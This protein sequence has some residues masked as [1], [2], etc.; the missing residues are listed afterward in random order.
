M[1]AFFSILTVLLVM[2][3]NAQKYDCTVKTKE[4]QD[5]IKS[6]KIAESYNDWNEVRKNCPKENEAI[7]TDGITI[8]EY[9]I[10]NVTAVEE[11]E[12]LVREEMS[13][14]DQYYRNFP[15]S[16][17]N[18]EAQKAMALY[19]HKIEANNEIVELLNS[20]FTKT[21]KSITEAN[22]FYTY[23]SL[24][25]AKY[26]EDS[27]NYTSDM[28]LDKYMQINTLIDALISTN[29]TKSSD[30]KSAQR[31]IHALAKDITNCDVLS[32]Y[33]EK[34][35]ENNK[36]NA[37]WL[38]TAL[39]NFTV[40]CSGQPIYNAMAEANYKIKATTKSAYYLAN[41]SMKQRKF[42]E[43]I[44]YFTEAE[45]L[46]TNPLEKAKLDYSL[47]TGLLSGDKP[48][49]KELLLKAVSLDPKMGRAY[50][51]LAELYTNSAEECGQTPFQ[52][53]AIYYLAQTTI[54]KAALAEPILKTTVQRMTESLTSKSLTPTE[55][56]TEKMN[57]KSIKI[58]CWI[59]ETISFP[60]N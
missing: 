47:A 38:T 16:I 58:G 55:I 2:N 26:K 29:T 4:Y 54:N 49:A 27:K 60:S 39:S 52:K 5:L 43:A 11:K 35:F 30:Y 32:P 48:K 37:D 51:F 46:E 21:P 17:P 3:S 56:S 18:Y 12:K 15:S 57:G 9:K 14:Y 31:G 13:L 45:T 28:V 19:N 36:D 50:L 41:S 20:A 34:R 24:Y 53:K 1:K 23:F 40:K 42:P 7:Y 33:Y 8:L 10:D 25:Y 6:N 59:N 22:V 44:K